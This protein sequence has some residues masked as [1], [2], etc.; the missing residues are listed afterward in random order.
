MSSL[1]DTKRSLRFPGP[2]G[3]YIYHS[4]IN[5][6]SLQITVITTEICDI[7]VFPVDFTKD[8]QDIYISD[9]KILVPTED[10]KVRGKKE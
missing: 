10:K 8:W 2:L 9:H 6:K 5:M 3:W 1:R 7:N 4:G